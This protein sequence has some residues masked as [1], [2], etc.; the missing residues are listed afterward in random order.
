M[1]LAPSGKT[2]A[3]RPRRAPQP[4][5]QRRSNRADICRAAGRENARPLCLKERDRM[6]RVAPRLK[7]R[8]RAAV[9]QLVRASDCGSEGRWFESTRLYQS[10]HCL[11]NSSSLRPF[12]DCPALRR[13]PFCAP[14]RPCSAGFT[15]LKT[16]RRRPRAPER[17]L[18]AILAAD[19]EGYSRLMH[20]DEE[21]TLAVLTA[22]RDDHRQADPRRA[23]RD[24]GTAGDSVLAEFSSVVEA[25]H[26]PSQSSRRSPR[27]MPPCRRTSACSC[28][29]AS[30]SAT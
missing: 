18:A 9:A 4:E 14:W 28:A 16:G 24:F 20:A 13:T 15:C 21:R 19:V 22:H 7:M 27:R 8:P 12:Q 3:S 5:A 11:R 25:F 23:R 17:K 26:A 30:M 6:S 10:P 29:S 1:I 2:A